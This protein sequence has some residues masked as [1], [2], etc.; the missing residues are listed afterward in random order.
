MTEWT[1]VATQY[2]IIRHT[3]SRAQIIGSEWGGAP[4]PNNS[5]YSVPRHLKE[6][7]SF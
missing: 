1:D 3:D 6:T 7:L 4:P 5:G 2:P